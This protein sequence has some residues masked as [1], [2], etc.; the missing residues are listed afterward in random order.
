[1]LVLQYVS[2]VLYLNK[3]SKAR[4]RFPHDEPQEDGTVG[5]IG[6]NDPCPCGSGKKYKHCCGAISQSSPETIYGRIRRLDGESGDLLLKYAKQRYGENGFERAL[7]EF[8]HDDENP[9]DISS[10]EGESFVRWF[11]FNWRPEEMQTL[12][13]E[14][15]SEKKAT[16]HGDLIRFIRATM[17]APYSY[18]QAIE[19]DPG[20][21]LTLRDILRRGELQVIEKSASTILQKGQILFARVVEMDGIQFLMGSGALI[22]S[23]R[24]LDRLMFMRSFLEKHSPHSDGTVTAET[25]LAMEEELRELYFEIEEDI[26][27]PKISLR[28]TDNDPLILHTLTYKISSAENVFHTLKD[29][30]QKCTQSSDDELLSD[31]ERNESGA[32]SKATIR[33]MKKSK[34]GPLGGFT[35]LG[36]LTITTSELAVEVNSK[37]RARSIQRE[38]Q[39]RLGDAAVLVTTK[40]K[41]AEEMLD[42]RSSMESDPE[43]EEQAE[44]DR[45]LNNSPEAKELMRELSDR[46]WAEWP[47][48]PLPGLR[49]KTPRQAV[50]DPDCCELLE[51]MLMDFEIR[52]HD[53][54]DKFLRVDVAKLRRELGL[55][56]RRP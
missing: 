24:Y 20:N 30:E 38:I 37:K 43:R 22:I 1:M 6:R 23:P 31:A 27:H 42:D 4:S 3:F 19:V 5:N 47:N 18:F 53:Q 26:F 28:N 32:L 46:H 33:W 40:T 51:S 8:G 10:P 34:K 2:E 11:L 14:F 41:S 56:S 50:K 17:D 48:T 54:D 39:K 55:D 9:I 29:L 21:G 25:L 35:T 44:R 7:E 13:E 45:M 52:N 36:T 15:L 49:G 16:I 12:A